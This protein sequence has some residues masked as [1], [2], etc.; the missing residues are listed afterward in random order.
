MQTLAKAWRHL[1][2]AA[3]VSVAGLRAATSE[4]AFRMEIVVLVLALVLAPWLA[5]SWW[6]GAL[7]VAFVVLTMALE[8]VNTAIEAACDRITQ[9][10]DPLVKR[11]KDCASAAVMLAAIATALVWAGALIARFQ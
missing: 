5:R 11:A 1:V 4:M 9:D 3:S 10:K 7:L 8:L 6:Q 2:R